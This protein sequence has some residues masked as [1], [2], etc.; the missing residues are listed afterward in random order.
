MRNEHKIGE[1]QREETIFNFI[2][3]KT[4]EIL[5]VTYSYILYIF[6]YIIEH[7]DRF[8]TM[9]VIKPGELCDGV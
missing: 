2:I 9:P 7:Y 6:S 8:I 5:N 4:S 3:L 1:T